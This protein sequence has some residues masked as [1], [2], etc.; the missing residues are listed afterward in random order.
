LTKHSEF[1]Q[2]CNEKSSVIVNVYCCVEQWRSQPKT[3]G[4]KNLFTLNE[5]TN[6][7]ALFGIQPLKARNDKIC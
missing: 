7:R 1:F 3:F 5:Q 2:F 4:S 6:I